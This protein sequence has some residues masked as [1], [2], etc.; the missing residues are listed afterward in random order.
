MKEVQA[1]P[2]WN[3]GSLEKLMENVK[4]DPYGWAP[5]PLDVCTRAFIQSRIEKLR[6]RYVALGESAR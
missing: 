2:T 3:D 1:H 4:L 6:V 5:E